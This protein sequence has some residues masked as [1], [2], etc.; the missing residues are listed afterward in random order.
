MSLK[1]EGGVGGEGKEGGGRGEISPFVKAEVSGP[2]G[3]TAQKG[4]TCILAVALIQKPKNAKKAKCYR[5][6]NQMTNHMTNH[7]TIQS[8]DTAIIEL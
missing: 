3:S 7:M 6:T 5:P 1:T 8:T 2:E 4:K